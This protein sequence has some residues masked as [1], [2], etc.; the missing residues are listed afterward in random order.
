MPSCTLAQPSFV[1]AS[2]A[3][4]N[5]SIDEVTRRT[6]YGGVFTSERENL[7]EL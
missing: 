6:G 4:M 2:W 3:G 7:Q 5:G 1:G